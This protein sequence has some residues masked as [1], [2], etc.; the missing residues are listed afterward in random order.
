LPDRGRK[1]SFFK[2]FENEMKSTKLVGLND[3]IGKINGVM[4]RVEMAFGRNK[5][6]KV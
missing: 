6:A 5:W 2:N 4:E 1:D 3:S